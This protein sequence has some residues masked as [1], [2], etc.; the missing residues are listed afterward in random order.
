[1]QRFPLAAIQVQA[2]IVF[3][4]GMMLGAAWYFLIDFEPS[5]YA[6]MGGA[7]LSALAV[8]IAK[9]KGVSSSVVALA[10]ALTGMAIGAL[11][12]APEPLRVDQPTIPP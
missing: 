12:G 2:P 8:F 7:G 6:L 10:W 11:P 3:A 4:I 5:L 9:F 1:M